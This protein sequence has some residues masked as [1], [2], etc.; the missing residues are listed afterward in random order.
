MEHSEAGGGLYG[1]GGDGS[2]TG[3]A[4]GGAHD[5]ADLGGDA[6]GVGTPPAPV[7][8]AEGATPMISADLLRMAADPHYHTPDPAEVKDLADKIDAAIQR[9]HAVERRV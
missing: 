7:P 4:R 1:A 9:V 8:D 6:G 3:D 5:P 2:G